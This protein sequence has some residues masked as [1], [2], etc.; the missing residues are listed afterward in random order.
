M[1]R[2]PDFFLKKLIFKAFSLEVQKSFQNPFSRLNSLK[3]FARVSFPITFHL[4][5]PRQQ[6]E[7]E[8][9]KTASR[10]IERV[11]GREVHS[12]E[13]EAAHI[14]TPIDSPIRCIP[15]PQEWPQPL[16]TSCNHTYQ[17]QLRR[18]RVHGRPSSSSA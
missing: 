3:T 2:F 1:H 14:T 7:K 17:E 18:G 10:R 5:P 12:P 8:N 6:P 4:S 11:H 16:Q 9:V 15:S 13:S